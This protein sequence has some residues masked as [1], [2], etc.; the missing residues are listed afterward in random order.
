MEAGSA[1]RRIAYY[2]VPMLFCLA[3]HQC[4]LKT[5][6]FQ[7]DFAWLALRLGINSPSDLLHALFAPIA[8]G[9]VRTLSERLYFLVFPSLFGLNVA[10]LQ[11]RTS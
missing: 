9:T 3:L 1:Y 10:A 7:D 11:N 4:A 6:F 2:G 8:Q 5:W